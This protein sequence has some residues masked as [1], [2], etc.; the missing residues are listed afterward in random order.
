M[1]NKIFTA[2]AFAVGGAAGFLAGKIFFSEKYKRIAQEEVETVK[3]VYKKYKEHK[4][5]AEAASASAADEKKEDPPKEPSRPAVKPKP[6]L[7]NYAKYAQ[8]LG[9]PLPPDLPPTHSE[10]GPFIIKPEEFGEEDGFDVVNLTYYS[11]FVLADERDAALADDEIERTIGLASLKRFGEY[12]YDTIFVRNP[13]LRTDFEVTLDNRT[14][15]EVVGEK[16]YILKE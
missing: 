11:D 7:A 4:K 2:V 15:L 13:M 16:P 9:R 12:E 14:Y 6:D 3:A 10:S 1:N 5:T 8:V